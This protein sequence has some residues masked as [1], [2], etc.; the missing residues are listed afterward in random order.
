MWIIWRRR[1]ER[2]A[3]W[4]GGG[5]QRRVKGTASSLWEGECASAIFVRMP[6]CRADPKIERVTRGDF[7]FPLGVYPV[8]EL[9]PKAGYVVEFESA[10]GDEEGGEWEEWPDRYVFDIVVSADRLEA[11]CRR[12]F[13]MLPA[14]VY[15]ILDV[16]GRDAY[17][18]IDPYI[19]YEL[20]GWDRFVGGVWRYRDFFFEDG[21]VGFGAMC[22]DP[23]F[24]VFVDEHKIIT[25]RAETQWKEKIEKTLEA[26]DLEVTAEPKGADSAA[27]EHRSVLLMP[28]DEPLVLGPDE[29]VERLRD[30][31]HLV[32]N[33]DPDTNVDEKG[34]EL[35]VTPW[36]VI[37]RCESPDEKRAKAYAEVLLKANNVRAAEEAAFEGVDGLEMPKGVDEWADMVIITADR[38]TEE[39]LEEAMEGE[40]EKAGKRKKLAKARPKTDRIKRS[41]RSE[42][43]TEMPMGE[44][45]V[46]RARWISPHGGV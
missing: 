21:M 1:G 43:E 20:L 25:V 34:Q 36:R 9:E 22:D 23:F 15:P 41:G 42:E 32:L 39:S 16:L 10:D 24:Y 27:H 38:L 29:I 40:G 2:G 14:R 5:V 8:E 18:E 46:V 19:S 3:G 28:E 26:F 37:V 30:D 12:L 7:K 4:K 17:R 45:E 13:S 44:A 35:G 33:V 11:L 31:W 6:T